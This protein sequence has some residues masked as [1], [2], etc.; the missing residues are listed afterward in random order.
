VWI[1]SPKGSPTG[2]RTAPEAAK[3]EQDEAH[4]R[5]TVATL[6]RDGHT[7]TM[8]AIRAASKL[9]HAD[10]ADALERL[11]IAGELAESTGSRRARVFTLQSECVSGSH[12]KGVGTG[13]HSHDR[14]PEPVG[15]SGNQSGESGGGSPGGDAG[16]EEE[17]EGPTADLP[18]EEAA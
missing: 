13:N 5:D 11:V 12:T 15:T 4:V 8:R 6:L 17:E 16:A 2:E 9:R 14:F 7:P 10:T 18:G 3:R 1:S